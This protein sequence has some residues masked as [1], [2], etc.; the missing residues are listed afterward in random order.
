[1]A[2]PDGWGRRCELQIQNA[3][4][5]ANLTNFPVLLT[6][7]TLPAE[8][9]AVAGSFEAIE[10][11]GDIRFSSDQA[12]SS[13]L[14]CE[15]VTFSLDDA[16]DEAEI[17]VNVAS[18]SSSAD[19]SIWVWYSKAA[20]SQPAEGAAFG[21]HATWDTNFKGVWHLNESSGGAA[22]VKDSTGEGNDLTDGGSPTF[23]AAGKVG[24]AIS[25]D[26]DNDQ[27]ALAGGLDY[28]TNLTLSAWG[29][30]TDLT[31]QFAT[32]IE[33]ANRNQSPEEIQYWFGIDGSGY[34]I[35]WA[36]DGSGN[37]AQFTDDQNTVAT[38]TLKHVAVTYDT[39]TVYTYIDGIQSDTGALGLNPLVSSI[40]PFT[41]GEGFTA[42]EALGDNYEWQGI[43]DEIRVSNDDRAVEWINAGFENQN[44][45]A[46]FVV[47]QSPESPVSSIVVLRRRRM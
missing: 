6:K 41:V 22:A 33:K 4:V 14:A 2:F 10:G 43:L 3:K 1:M 28:T 26:G 46:T 32:I 19:T 38:G 42:G 31:E 8:M 23:G 37:W 24:D 27:L 40:G 17:W 18:V 15:I 11:G 47:E 12:G 7:A 5:D 13:R 20:E 21:Q 39:G 35:F 16:N 36:K 34:I 25:F 45:P 30:L 29:N 9:F 44:D